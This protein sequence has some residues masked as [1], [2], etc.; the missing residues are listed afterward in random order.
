[1]K[2]ALVSLED[3]LSRTPPIGLAY[4]ATY[5]EKKS[6]IKDTV[7]VD[8]V[9]EDIHERLKEENPDLIGIS[10]MSL[11]YGTAI[12]TAREIRNYYTGQIIIGGVHISTMPESLKDVFD[13]AVL[14]EGEE[15]LREIVEHFIKKGPLQEETLKDIKGVA[16]FGNDGKVMLTPPRPLVKDL[17]DI[18]WPDFKYIN[19][20]YLLPREE[21]GLRMI[22]PCAPLMTAR[23]CPY[24]CVFCST[25]T[26]WDRHRN[27][28]VDYV[29]GNIRY[30]VHDLG[31]KIINILDDMFIVNKNRLKELHAKLGQE[32]LLGKATFTCNARSNHI[33]DEMCEILKSLNVR[34]LNFGFE[35]GSE[36]MLKY[37]KVGSTSV[38]KN[39]DAIRTCKR[40]GLVVYGS[41]MFGSPGETIE[42]MEKTLDFIRFAKKE[43]ADYL[44]SFVATPFPKTE[45]WEVAKRR[46]KVRDDADWEGEDLMSHQNVEHPT[47]TDVSMEEFR[48]VFGKGRSLLRGMR[49]RLIARFF[50]KNP[51][52]VAGLFA[53]NIPHYVKRFY[54]LVFRF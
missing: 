19:P 36:R 5:L 13:F 28:S 4:L 6:G 49:Y 20:N 3:G 15:T 21:V 17:D 10:A 24:R 34:N 39:K 25:S 23:G 45:F 32:G 7:I 42:D 9:F 53:K 35:S 51:I 44:W 50:L 26:F 2:L 43:K 40:H 8:N 16:Y 47:L 29:V 22:G 11:R 12:K 52:A 38:Q 33:D 27:H 30:L 54:Y 41:L 18:P 14:G 37:L 1:M 31:I 46:G 48:K